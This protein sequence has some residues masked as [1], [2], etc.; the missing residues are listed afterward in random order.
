L[1]VLV[2][3]LGGAFV[4]GCS[5]DDAVMF[6]PAPDAGTGDG[7]GADSTAGDEGGSGQDGSTGLDAGA[8]T[9]APLSCPAYTGNDTYCKA[10]SA[11]CGRC[12]AQL[13]ACEIQNVANCELFS[14]IFSQNARVAAA[15]CVDK[16]TCAMD[17]G[18]RCVLNKLSKDT[19][20]AAQQNLA[21][22]FCNVCPGAQST[23]AC[24]ADFFFK[25]DGGGGGKG[26]Y[27]MELKDG[28]VDAIDKAC[29]PLITSDAGDAGV[30]GCAAKFTAC[31]AVVLGKVAPADA[32]KDAGK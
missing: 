15:D 32:C 8:D 21:Q 24:V 19:P 10:V 7:G 12:V 28:L 13:A 4:W 25:A 30:A 6:N 26:D 29:V 14:Q 31:A 20:S 2:F 9:L 11:Y 16:A 22:D 23:S 5:G 1:S 27:I 18:E 3:S 17:G